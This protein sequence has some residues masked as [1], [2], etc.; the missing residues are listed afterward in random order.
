MHR[1][2]AKNMLREFTIADY[3]Y[4][5]DKHAKKKLHREVY[6]AGY[7]DSFKQRTLKTTDLELI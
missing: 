7:P 2:H 1:I 3:P 6:K 5:K 4:I